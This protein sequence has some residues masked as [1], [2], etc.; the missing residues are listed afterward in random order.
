MQK[1]LVPS[2]AS[3]LLIT[4]LFIFPLFGQA[5]ADPLSAGQKM[6]YTM[7]KNN[8]IRAA[9]KMPE[10]NY[11][12]KPVP[13][14]RSFGQI[15]GHVADAQYAFCSAA[16]GEKNPGLNIEKSKTTKADLVQALKEAFAYADKAYDGLTDAQ[17]SQII[18]VFGRDQAKLTALAFNTVH[19]MEH[20]G[21]LVTYLRIKGL[22]P[23]SS[24]PRK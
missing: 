3:F 2:A 7:A 8:L 6:L 10:E 22:V 13:E 14:V 20:Y 5:P 16:L 15:L 17:A 9:E 21:N 24:E 18:K 23:P 1:R 4:S 12:F 19:N 11:S